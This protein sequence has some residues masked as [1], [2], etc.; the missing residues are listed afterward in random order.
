MVF[1]DEILEFEHNMMILGE[2]NPEK[3][4]NRSFSVIYSE[5]WSKNVQM[6]VTRNINYFFQ[7]LSSPTIFKIFA[8]GGYKLMKPYIWFLVPEIGES[9]K[10]PSKNVFGGSK[11]QF[12][13]EIFFQKG[14]QKLKKG[15][16]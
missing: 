6:R 5:N 10:H 9:V 7:I 11:I 16:H 12:S 1:T 3:N 13:G 14:D 8:N 15:L 2:K 4:S